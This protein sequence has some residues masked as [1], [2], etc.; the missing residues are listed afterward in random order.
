MATDR[1]R[2]NGNW[3]DLRSVIFYEWCHS[4]SVQFS[5]YR[6]CSC[7][8]FNSPKCSLIAVVLQEMPISF[9]NM[10]GCIA[11]CGFTIYSAH[12]LLIVF[13]YS[14]AFK[15]YFTSFICKKWDKQSSCTSCPRHHN[16]SAWFPQLPLSIIDETS[17][18]GL[19]CCTAGCSLLWADAAAAERDQLMPRE[20]K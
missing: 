4:Y 10:A 2:K 8:L 16:S 7:F 3:I 6:Q 11:R 13:G 18:A 12:Q 17:S 19:I 15:Q 9:Q 5:I 14:C 20:A 1:W